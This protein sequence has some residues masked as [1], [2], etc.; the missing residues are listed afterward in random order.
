MKTQHNVS[1][2]CSVFGHH[3]S[4]CSVA[5]ST[6]FMTNNRSQCWK[7]VEH[8]MF[9]CCHTA[10]SAGGGTALWGVEVKAIL[11]WLGAEGV[12]AFMCDCT[13]RTNV[14]HKIKLHFERW[15]QS[16]RNSSSKEKKLNM[17]EFWGNFFFSLY[18]TKIYVEHT[19][20]V[21]TALYIKINHFIWLLVQRFMPSARPQWYHNGT[22]AL[23]TTFK[24]KRSLHRMRLG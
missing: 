18:Q 19:T 16:S 2:E 9:K 3:D 5:K 22:R 6:V 7:S 15:T 12:C 21:F 1:S 17:Q 8:N 20:H 10:F 13:E 23:I 24:F 11:L 4:G 14:Y